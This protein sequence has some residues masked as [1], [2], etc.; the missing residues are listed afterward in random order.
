M[1]DKTHF[2]TFKKIVEKHPDMEIFVGKNRKEKNMRDID[3][4]EFYEDVIKWGEESKKGLVCG[5]YGC[6]EPVIIRC[7]ICGGGYCEEHKGMHFHSKDN[8]GIYLRKVEEA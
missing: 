2:D 8:D 5:I 4:K 7:K 3:T 1:P 6:I